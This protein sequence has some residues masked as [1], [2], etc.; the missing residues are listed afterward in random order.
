MAKF[1]TRLRAASGAASLLLCLG[2]IA[3]SDGALA[4]TAEPPKFVAPI[5][6]EPPAGTR[7]NVVADR[8]TYDGKSDIATATGTVR[9]TYGPYTLTATKVV[10]DRRKDLFRANGS[11]ELREPNGNIMQAEMAEM[12]DKFKEGFAAHVRALLTNDVTI[13]AGY[14]R[15]YENGITVY[16][17]VTYTACKA[18]VD[19]G[20]TPLWQIVSRETTHDQQERTLYY[21]DARLEIGGVPVFWTPYFSYPDP[22]VKRRTGW[23]IP[24]ANYGRAYGLGVNTPY[25]WA[26]QPNADLT[27]TPRWTT[28][29]GVLADAEWRHRLRS[30]LYTLRGSGIYELDPSRTREDSRWRGAVSSTG[31]F[32]IDNTWSW[33]WDGTLVSDRSFLDDYDIDNDDMA[34][35]SLHVTGLADRNY[36][37]AQ[38]LHYRTL[39]NGE[40]QDFMPV[41]LPYVSTSYIFDQTMLGGEVSFDMNAYSLSRRDPDPRFDLGSE[42]TR[43]VANLGWQRQFISGMGQL[44]TPFASMRGDI[45]LAENVPG[46]TGTEET[47]AHLLPLAGVDVRWPFI[48][49]HGYAQSVVTPVFQIIAA[50]DEQDDA[51]IGNEDAIT[52][53]FDH[54]NLFLTDRF[55]G[56]DRY[57][58]GTRINAGVVYNL[59]AANGGFL[60]ASAGE[61][62]HVAGE[63]SFVA[64][65]GLDGSKSDLVAA[66]AFQPNDTLRFTYQARIE[67]DLSQINV[68]EASVGLTFD[69]I[70]GSLSY[71]DIAAATAYGR[72]SDEQQVWG[73]ARFAFSDA[74]SLF[75]GFRYDIEDSVFIDKSIGVAF[76]CDC[77]NARLTYS[78]GRDRDNRLDHSL[79]L[80]VEL[81]T[82]GAVAGGF[83][84]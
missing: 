6:K 15:R 20:G 44:V 46:A 62:F 50:A 68:Q 43:A 3:G 76:D 13:T 35:S 57:E 61:S 53:N 58:G 9:I 2:L 31:D 69:R 10:Y 18:C 16:E 56:F 55:S 33:G 82:I 28:G 11:V 73:D 72:A 75:G 54:T 38:A 65:S 29:Q 45:Y 26:V 22:T 34:V 4:A 23:L 48:A 25:F 63:N 37:T 60:R 66:I 5:F 70:S 14:A 42:Q 77:M 19:E 7:V 83:K 17:N 79:K 36:A 78:E 84:F 51:D 67:E 27:V 74:W 1:S 47:S 52:L 30:G 41:V 81:R 40:N 64:G 21:R 8:L 71:A 80:S 49:D 59:L 12:N 32:R 39:L 24:S